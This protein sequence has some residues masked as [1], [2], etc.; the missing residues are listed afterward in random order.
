MPQIPLAVQ[1]SFMY[2]P[3]TPGVCVSGCNNEGTS[4]DQAL[5]TFL[6]Y[7]RNV[8]PVSYCFFFCGFFFILLGTAVIPAYPEDLNEFGALGGSGRLL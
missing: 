3:Q 6:C 4:L 7:F 8:S 1:R 2:V 5:A